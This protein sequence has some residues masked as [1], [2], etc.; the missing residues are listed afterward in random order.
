MSY[1]HLL[2]LIMKGRVSRPFMIKGRVSR[3]IRSSLPK[4]L[5]LPGAPHA[6]SRALDHV[7]GDR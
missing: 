3:P 2:R 7:R 4:P 1:P 5:K 6:L